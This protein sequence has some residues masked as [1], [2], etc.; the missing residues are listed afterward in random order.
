M[1]HFPS[2]PRNPGYSCC[3]CEGG[4]GNQ[5]SV[6]FN[7]VT[8]HLRRGATQMNA[9][10]AIAPGDFSEPMLAGL[11]A[12]ELGTVLEPRRASAGKELLWRLFDLAVASA[13]LL[14]A[15][16]FLLVL[17]AV[18]YLTDPGPLFFV[19]RR[20]G[21]RGGH[22]G[23]I[24]LR[25]MKV[26]GDAILREHLAGQSG[27]ADRVGRNPEAALRPA[28]DCDRHFRSQAQPR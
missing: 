1:G 25:T 19:H 13:I 24:K 28:G 5:S 16:P 2:F 17:A 11:L 8:R 23:C 21:L 12:S 4:G 7:Y 20:I 27:G 26:D 6:E 15:L 22:F 14:V 10:F 3:N 18:M 9:Q